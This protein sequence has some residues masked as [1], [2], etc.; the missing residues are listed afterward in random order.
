MVADEDLI[1]VE[2][3]LQAS[4]L[5]AALRVLNDR[6]PHRFTAVYKVEDGAMRNVAIV[7]KAGEV[8]P[9]DFLTVPLQKSFCQ[10]VLKDGGFRTGNSALEDRLEGH[11][12][13]GV[14]NSYVGLPITTAG[15]ELFGTLCHFDFPPQAMTDGEYEFLAKAALLLPPYVIS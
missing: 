2:Q 15:G 6:V 3:A 8:V 12:Y 10:F 14:M 4:G 11:V 7:D 13:K 9:A 1:R 5:N